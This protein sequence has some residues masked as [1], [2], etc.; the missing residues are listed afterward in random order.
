MNNNLLGGLGQCDKCGEWHN[1]ISYYSEHEC[2]KLEKSKEQKFLDT[3]LEE[4]KAD[5]Q[6]SRMSYKELADHCIQ[7]I[8]SKEEF[9]SLNLAAMDRVIRILFE[10]NDDYKEENVD[11]NKDL[12]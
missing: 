8:W 5:E 10:L 9:G 7:N 1:N 6:I 11:K 2:K 12:V 4:I 3:V